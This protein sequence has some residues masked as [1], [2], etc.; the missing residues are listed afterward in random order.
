MT[1]PERLKINEYFSFFT[2]GNK[3]QMLS[4]FTMSGLYRKEKGQKYL[5]RTANVAINTLVAA[6][7]KIKYQ[8]K[9]EKAVPRARNSEDTSSK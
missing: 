9:I 7:N 4:I 6:A 1:I 2:K 5:D 8:D 3:D